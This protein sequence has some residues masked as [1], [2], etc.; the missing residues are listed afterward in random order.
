MDINGEK[1]EIKDNDEN[2]E[3]M[4]HYDAEQIKDNNE[5]NGDM[6]DYENFEENIEIKRFDPVKLLK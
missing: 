5:K 1:E 2:H 3:D 4:N 6:N